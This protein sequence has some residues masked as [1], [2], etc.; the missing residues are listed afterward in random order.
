[1]DLDTPVLRPTSTARP[2]DAH[3]P[4]KHPNHIFN[5]EVGNG[6]VTDEAF[7]TAEVTIKELISYH[8]TH[9]SPL[10]NLPV[11]ELIRQG[12]G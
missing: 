1:M 6:A 9:P 11:P 7:N 12:E 10:E 4:R 8:R 2:V 5:W 3:G